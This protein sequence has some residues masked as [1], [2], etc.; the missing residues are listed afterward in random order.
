MPQS[1][2]GCEL[3][4]N[5]NCQLG[6]W[7]DFF[8]NWQQDSNRTPVPATITSMDCSLSYISHINHQFDGHPRFQ[9][10]T[11]QLFG[12][13]TT[14]V[15][16]SSCVGSHIT[17]ATQ[18]GVMIRNPNLTVS[19]EHIKFA[20]HLALFTIQYSLF[21]RPVNFISKKTLEKFEK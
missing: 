21:A 9:R 6:M 10:E 8:L 19:K 11:D 7:Y 15:I 18:T 3:E 5:C 20:E 17:K 4:L 13:S 16:P 14:R 2:D 12:H 1:S